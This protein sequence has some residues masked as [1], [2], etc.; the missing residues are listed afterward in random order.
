MRQALSRWSWRCERLVGW[1]LLLAAIVAL[2]GCLK[3]DKPTF[4]KREA[5]VAMIGTL[6]YDALV[7]AGLGAGAGPQFSA[8]ANDVDAY[9]RS[10]DFSEE[11]AKALKVALTTT[12]PGDTDVRM[13][14]WNVMNGILS[15]DAK[16]VSSEFGPRWLSFGTCLESLH[17][18]LG[19]SAPTTA[20]TA[21]S[22]QMALD[23]ARASFASPM[24][25][26]LFQVARELPLPD[27]MK[28]HLDAAELTDT[29]DLESCRAGAEHLR[30]LL[31]MSKAVS[32]EGPE[33]LDR[34]P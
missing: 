24:G 4:T 3:E 30:M 18:A 1:C 2:G 11:S 21:Q 27:K 32:R 22:Q 19:L 25:T 13:Q 17:L 14:L 12:L 15:E 29:S 8:S 28:T 31:Q 7:K 26:V 10:A 34:F 16:R 33:A 23:L 9:C 20:P 5:A 6:S